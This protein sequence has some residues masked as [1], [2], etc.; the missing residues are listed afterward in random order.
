MKHKDDIAMIVFI[1]VLYIIQLYLN[2]FT[3]YHIMALSF[4]YGGYTVLRLFVYVQQKM[5]IKK[6]LVKELDEI[7]RIDK[8]KSDRPRWIK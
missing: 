1:P 5:A 4:A 7:N 2:V 6:G 3:I 8:D